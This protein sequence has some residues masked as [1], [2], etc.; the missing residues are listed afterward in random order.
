MSAESF[1]NLKHSEKSYII[2]KE[3]RQTRCAWSEQ[4]CSVFLG[5][6]L[7]G[8]SA[9]ITQTPNTQ[10][11]NISS[12]LLHNYLAKVRHIQ[13]SWKRIG[14]EI[15]CS[16]MLYRMGYIGGVCAVAGRVCWFNFLR[17]LRWHR[18]AYDFTPAAI[19]R[20]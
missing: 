11:P 12:L 10:H 16:D 3:F 7:L 13:A 8:W 14:A 18:K 19:K 1:R 4:E 15:L 17:S 2:C 6:P 5:S 20:V 9:Y